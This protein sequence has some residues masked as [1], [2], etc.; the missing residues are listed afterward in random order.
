ACCL[1]V[2]PGL[3]LTAW[4]DARRGVGGQAGGDF[5]AGKAR[6]GFPAS[7]VRRVSH[8]HD[9]GDRD[10]A[11]AARSGGFPSRAWPAPLREF[12][13]QAEGEAGASDDEEGL[14]VEFRYD[15][16]ERPGNDE[17]LLAEQVPV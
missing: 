7:D 12:E 17:A 16:I 15:Q 6:A 8:G 14:L 1:H 4:G 13:K 11:G 9:G 5:A 10:V 3:I 2:R